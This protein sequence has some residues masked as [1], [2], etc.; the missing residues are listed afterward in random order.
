MNKKK[1]PNLVDQLSMS[2]CCMISVRRYDVCGNFDYRSDVMIY[3]WNVRSV[4]LILKLDRPRFPVRCHD[5]SCNRITIT[6]RIR[7]C[8][9]LTVLQQLKIFTVLMWYLVI[10]LAIKFKQNKKYIMPS[11]CHICSLITY[12]REHHFPLS[13]VTPTTTERGSGARRQGLVFKKN[14][15]LYSL[16][17][18]HCI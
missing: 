15:I 9:C 4:L 8:C 16:P 14:L 7:N 17:L 6:L 12:S 10:R 18:K 2:S 5:V 13:Q 1:Q 11:T 3:S